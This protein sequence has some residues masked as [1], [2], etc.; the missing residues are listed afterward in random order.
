VGVSCYTYKVVKITALFICLTIFGLTILVSPTLAAETNMATLSLV[1]SADNFTVGSEFEVAVI[2]DSGGQPINVIDVVVYFPEDL[3]EV[4]GPPT[5]D[6][7]LPL[8]QFNASNEKGEINIVGGE[9]QNGVIA[10]NSE[11]TR[12]RFKVKQEGKAVLKISSK[13][14]NI[15]AADGFGTKIPIK[16]GEA[17]YSLTTGPVVIET[18]DLEAQ[19]P[20]VAISLKT[21][22]VEQKTSLV[23][24]ELK[25][26][27]LVLTEWMP[28]Q[29]VKIPN[30]EAQ[31]PSWVS[32]IKINFAGLFVA[33]VAIIYNLRPDLKRAQDKK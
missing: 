21:P 7:L 23:T 9:R 28:W 20:S 32:V 25:A 12:I 27:T 26:M 11:I 10:S 4:I 33:F 24:E 19:L 30:L 8:W 2:L 31:L 3:I 16:A 29:I 13:N 22:V 14:S 18:P 17:Y 15:I 5:R 6:G 1:P